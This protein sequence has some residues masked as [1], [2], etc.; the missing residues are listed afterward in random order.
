MSDR[1]SG[2]ASIPQERPSRGAPNRRE[3]LMVSENTPAKFLLIIP[4]G[5]GDVH[6]VNGRS[7]LAEAA[8]PHWDEVASAG[9]CGLMQTLYEDL[10][11]GSVV[12]HLGMLGWDPHLFSGHG[13]AG[14]ELLALGE[15]TLAPG[16]LAFRA[17]LAQVVKRRLISYN[18][19]FIASEMALPLVERVNATLRDEFPQIELY[20]NCDFRNSLV[21]R[22]ANINP[23]LLICPEPHD[24]ERRECDPAR[25]IGAKDTE[26]QGVASLLNAYLA[27]AAEVLS[28]EAAN[29]IFPWSASRS[30]SLPRFRDHVGFKGRTAIVGSMDFLQGIARS[31]GIE[32]FKA[33]NGRPDT[34]YAAK[35]IKVI[36]LFEAGCSFVICHI[37]APDE[38]S[39]MHDRKIKVQCLEAIDRHIVGPLVRYFRARMDELGGMMIVPDHYTNLLIDS[40]RGDAHSLHPVP[41]ALWNGR[42][43]DGVTRFH[44]DAARHGLYGDKPIS[45]FE[46]LRILGVAG[47]GV[48][49]RPRAQEASLLAEI[50][51][52]PEIGL[53]SAPL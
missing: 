33:G 14:W 18:A 2:E 47:R 19:G 16:D 49:L 30:V 17:N 7:P 48:D 46:L 51:E 45:H 20:H 36:E 53:E 28:G 11:R 10:P 13:R 44:E 29:M 34:D 3:M 6:R 52:A 27:R 26:S 9:V 25:L 5:A 1:P 12:A 43:R 21:L 42:D 22:D 31:A 35:G 24:H 23:A 38:A 15:V 32:F 4:D 50:L 37:N 39:H 40:N 41:F 8:I